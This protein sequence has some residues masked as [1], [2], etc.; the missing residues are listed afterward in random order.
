MNVIYLHF[1]DVFRW[2]HRIKSSKH[3]LY[4]MKFAIEGLYN[5]GY[6]HVTLRSKFFSWCICISHELARILHSPS[7]WSYL[8]YHCHV[9]MNLLNLISRTSNEEDITVEFISV[10]CLFFVVMFSEKVKVNH[11]LNCFFFYICIA[12]KNTQ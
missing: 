2:Y 1:L 11:E 12:R 6:L 8:N 10:Y 4:K 3:L 7:R 5:L 9:F